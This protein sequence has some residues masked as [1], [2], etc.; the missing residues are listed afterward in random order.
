MK[1]IILCA[2]DYGQNP[3][4]SQAIVELMGLKRLSA[5]SCLVTSPFFD[6]AVSALQPYKNKVDIGLH[7]NLTEGTPLSKEMTAF[8]PLNDLILN[9]NL[10]ELKKPAII[11]EF[12]AQLDKFTEAFGQLPDF[13][14]GHQHVHQFPIIRDAIISV[15]EEKLRTN[16]TYIRCTYD[17]STLYRVS[18]VAYLKQ[19]IIQLCGGIIFK[20]RL[21]QFKIPHNQTFAGI[22]SFKSALSYPEY[23]PRFLNQVKDAGIVMCH[24]GL[25]SS[26]EE[27]EMANARY[28]EYSYFSSSELKHDLNTK[29]IKLI[30]FNDSIPPTA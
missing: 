20:K 14:D 16:K 2:D 19:L 6:Q 23:F 12:T 9:A 17:P 15:Y 27:N 11:A 26:D 3:A 8:Y 30:R 13:I 18:D 24:P 28:A 21:N 10:Y 4:I 7:F 5:T 25:Y 1:R 22:Y 29:Q